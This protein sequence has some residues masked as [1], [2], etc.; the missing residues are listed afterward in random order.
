MKSARRVAETDVEYRVIRVRRRRR[1]VFAP[2]KVLEIKSRQCRLSRYD[3]SNAVSVVAS[4]R[5]RILP[6]SSFLFSTL[7]VTFLVGSPRR[8][9][10]KVGTRL[11]LHR[12]RKFLARKIERSFYDLQ[13][14][15]GRSGAPRCTS[16]L[17]VLVASHKGLS[18]LERAKNGIYARS[19][20]IELRSFPPPPLFT[21]RNRKEDFLS[22]IGRY[23]GEL[24]F[25]LCQRNPNG[26]PRP[27]PIQL[28][29]SFVRW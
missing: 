12:T 21:W 26:Y 10:I 3:V 16:S 8:S 23:T 22:C 13:I 4:S 27:S 7:R 15:R 29:G 9:Y 17:A 6:N 20:S 1:Q 24:P 5:D 11:R 18:R 28:L 25:A 19:F 2:S 14:L